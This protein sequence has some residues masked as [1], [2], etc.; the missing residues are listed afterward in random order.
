MTID[1]QF[2][3]YGLHPPWSEGT[4]VVTR[5][6]I[7]SLGGSDDVSVTALSTIRR[8]EQPAT[9][10][11]VSYVG[12]SVVGD[13][14]AALGG[15]RYNADLPMLARLG[16]RLYA[17]ARDGR[18]DVVHAGFASHTL[19]S[20]LN[21]VAIDAGFVAQTFGG[22]EHRGLLSL[23]DTPER[24]DAYVSASTADI[25]ALR[26]F[27]L[28]SSKLHHVRV[29][30]FA[31]SLD[32]DPDAAREALDLPADAFVAGYIGNVNEDRFP[33]SFARRLNDFAADDGIE[34]LVVTKQ[35]EDRDVRDLE[36]LTVV[37]RHLDDREKA[38]AYRAADA[39]L[40]PFRFDDTSAP[41]IDPPLTVLEAMGAGR[42]VV[43]TATMSIPS[44]VED[45]RNGF[46]HD[47]EKQAAMIE[48]LRGLRDDP[49]L[50]RAVGERARA[51]IQ[52]RHDPTAVADDLRDVYQEVMG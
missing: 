7:R 48:T 26:S 28:P 49:D 20:L 8:S 22:I 11:D 39:W 5:D 38:M 42:P 12:E 31:D 46:L 25:E 30:V 16:A 4:R 36:N 52:D 24:I 40:F 14:V 47:V 27:G 19:F 33:F 29:P 10:L 13:L 44:L 2:L 23:F 35:I 51:T 1:V 9:G 15:Y 6:L 45:G 50:R 34:A 43:A 41:I 17:T 32:A 3:G 37:D 21:D 18:T